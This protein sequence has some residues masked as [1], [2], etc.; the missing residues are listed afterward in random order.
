MS[1]N[2]IDVLVIGA[3]PSGLTMAAEALRHGLTCR[4]IERKPSR[5]MNQSKALVI[6]AR[7][8]EQLH[9]MGDGRVTKRLSEVGTKMT[10]LRAHIG[11]LNKQQVR[12]HEFNEEGEEWGDTEFPFW[13][14]IPQQETES[15]L[16]EE[17]MHLGGHVEWSTCLESLKPKQPFADETEVSEDMSYKT[18]IVKRTGE[19][20]TGENTRETI[21]CR[22]VIGC[23][24]GRSFTR[25]EAKLKL[26]RESSDAFFFLADVELGS[27]SAKDKFKKDEGSVFIHPEGAMF[28]LPVGKDGLFRIMAHESAMSN[29]STSPDLR[30]SPDITK[31]FVDESVRK[32]CGININTQHITWSSVFRISYGVSNTYDNN[33]I[34]IAG[35]AAHVHS[36]VGGQGMNY[37]IQD[38]TNLV[39]KMAWAKRIMDDGA[40]SANENAI[41]TNI[42]KSYSSERREAAI[43]MIKGNVLATKGLVSTNPIIR[44][45][46]ETVMKLVFGGKRFKQMASQSLSMV[47]LK[48]DATNNPIL[49]IA[50]D[51]NFTSTCFSRR[52]SKENKW[53]PGSRVPNFIMSNG[54][55]VYDHIGRLRHTWLVIHNDTNATLETS[56]SIQTSTST[57][58]GK[59]PLINITARHEMKIPQ[60]V[61]LVRPDLYIAAIGDDID[62]MFRQVVHLFGTKATKFM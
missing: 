6:H 45:V 38:A 28:I 24:G 36:P 26:D 9:A 27:Q 59:I 21:Q 58:P 53:K 5:V 25:D 29:P 19:T 42:L 22:W 39:W 60:C 7:T 57:G 10:K 12:V 41:T 44:H 23:D 31:A 46:R 8:M 50:E 18:A 40:S 11:A 61:L 30:E 47:D 20:K 34:F 2:N 15:I 32:R 48:Y 43:K 17:L 55:K 3:G 62:E 4:I 33:G 56:Q 54:E 16:E 37:G 51:K 52:H 13:L 1:S 49:N 35:D 14:M